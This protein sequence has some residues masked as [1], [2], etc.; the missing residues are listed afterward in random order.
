MPFTAGVR[1]VGEVL[2]GLLHECDGGVVLEQEERERVAQLGVLG[3]G[4][5]RLLDA[6]GQR[7]EERGVEVRGLQTALEVVGDAAPGEGPIVSGAGRVG[8]E[9]RDVEACHEAS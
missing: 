9:D 2:G 8:R 4:R 1:I 3:C 7:G 6:A 5:E